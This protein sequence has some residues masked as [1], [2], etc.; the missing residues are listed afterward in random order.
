MGKFS[1][2][3]QVVVPELGLG[4]IIEEIE[5]YG[6]KCFKIVCGDVTVIRP[7]DEMAA[8]GVRVPSSKESV[9][10]VIKIL[11]GKRTHIKAPNNNQRYKRYREQ[12][13]SGDIK[14]LATLVR[15]LYT[16]DAGELGSQRYELYE[17]GL[18]RLTN[19]LVSVLQVPR[20]GARGIIESLIEREPLPPEWAEKLKTP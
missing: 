10:G 5:I 7:Q 8:S 17:K 1:V 14:E 4:T 6:K 11:R 19:E 13:N 16:K 20:L 18:Q 15:N 9:L 2:N 12:L 3:D